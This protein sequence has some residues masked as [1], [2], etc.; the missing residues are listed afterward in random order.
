MD[1]A[2]RRRINH[3]CVVGQ[4]LRPRGEA[5][6]SLGGGTFWQQARDIQ[7]HGQGRPDE[8]ISGLNTL[9]TL[10]G[11]LANEAVPSP[12]D[13]KSSTSLVDRD[14]VKGLLRNCWRHGRTLVLIRH[15][16]E[17]RGECWSCSRRWARNA[18][19]ASGS[20]RAT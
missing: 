6:P 20:S 4:E 10:H 19:S 18:T 13:I 7:S 17:R 2:G 15:A 11:D 9:G 8:P 3:F 12:D 5:R 16:R 14:W 1:D